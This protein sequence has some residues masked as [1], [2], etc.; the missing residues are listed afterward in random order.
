MV[1]YFKEIDNDRL[2]KNLV[3][4]HLDKIGRMKSLGI[5]YDQYNNY[6]QYH[7][8]DIENNCQY[9]QQIYEKYEKICEKDD[10]IDFDSILLYTFLLFKNNKIIREEYNNKYDYILVDEYQDTNLIQFK[11]LKLLTLLKEKIT[12]IGD[13]NQSIYKFRG[14]RIQN[15]EDF[16]KEYKN[17]KK[18]IL[19]KNFR[20]TDIIV[21]GA[22]VLIKKNKISIEK[23]LYSINILKDKIK[24]IIN[25]HNFEEANKIAYII[26][27][28]V[29][30]KKYEYRDFSILYRAN[31]QNLEFEKE[32]IRQRIPFTIFKKFSFFELKINKII[33]NYLK[34][35]ADLND[36]NS[37][38]YILNKPHKGIGKDTE[39][40][41]IFAS[42][43]LNLSYF[44]II[45]S[46]V[47][48]KKII[49]I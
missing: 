15:F 17:H 41:I 35:I 18:F 11:I 47:N 3:K 29:D 8:E 23:K 42:E 36:N 7:L 39:Q 16:A 44:E 28:Y 21:N 2:F 26:K 33:I 12:I 22:N 1:Y 19:Q 20:S 9:F 10:V 27:N 37:L 34:L 49:M 38:K 4:Y 46:I 5:T 48:K 30:N 6:S 31:M 40:K 45:S 13:E 24:I 14:A 32:F 25:E 43:K